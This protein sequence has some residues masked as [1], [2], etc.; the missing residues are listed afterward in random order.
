MTKGKKLLEIINEGMFIG[1]GIVFAITLITKDYQ[2]NDIIFKL[3]VAF[4]LMLLVRRS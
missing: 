4:G 2:V 3:M 1:L